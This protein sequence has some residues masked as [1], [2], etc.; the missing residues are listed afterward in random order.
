MTA[1]SRILFS[2]N[3]LESHSR[4]E[5]YLES[6][7]A[8]EHLRE[9]AQ[10][11][12]VPGEGK[13]GVLPVIWITATAPFRIYGY[14][15][16][17]AMGAILY[18][19]TPFRT[20][21]LNLS[22]FAKREVDYTGMVLSNYVLGIYSNVLVDMFNR[23]SFDAQ[24]IYSHAPIDLTD[25]SIDRAVARHFECYVDTKGHLNFDKLGGQCAGICDWIA[26]LYHETKYDFDDP[27]HHLVSLAKL[28]SN[29]APREAALMQLAQVDDPPIFGM[30]KNCVAFLKSPSPKDVKKVL[31]DLDPG[32]YSVT[33][34]SHRMN[35]VVT[36]HHTYLVQPTFGLVKQNPDQ[37]SHSLSKYSAL[38]V[39]SILPY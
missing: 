3:V 16:L 36:P 18:Y 27:E 23:H 10:K 29:G 4:F 13:L 34:Y 35:F 26:Y 2:K 39:C 28:V 31:E 7:D 21:A 20:T 1:M 12:Y 38:K 22:V 33:S 11:P 25:P 9:E 5:K 30:F 24:E 37:L 17:N 14:L 15:F 19:G 8:I 32:I 6:K